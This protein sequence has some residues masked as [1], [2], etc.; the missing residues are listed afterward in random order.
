[1]GKDAVGVV[2]EILPTLGAKPDYG[3]CRQLLKPISWKV[4]GAH[5]FVEMGG[6]RDRK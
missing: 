1:M 3:K 4:S 6:G 2:D 5:P